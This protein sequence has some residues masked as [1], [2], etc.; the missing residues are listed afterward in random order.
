MSRSDSEPAHVFEMFLYQFY[1]ISVFSLIAQY[2][3][4]IYNEDSI[5]HSYSDAARRAGRR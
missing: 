2:N 4:V 1:L 5:L 3:I